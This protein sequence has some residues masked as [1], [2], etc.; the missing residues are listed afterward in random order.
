MNKTP[1]QTRADKK[2]AGNHFKP[3]LF[4]NSNQYSHMRP[5]TKP[6]MTPKALPS[7]IRN[8]GKSSKVARHCSEEEWSDHK[9]FKSKI[10]RY[11]TY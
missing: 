3:S 7:Q 9:K 8:L 4:F 6:V 1:H 5:D 11:D 10:I 2:H